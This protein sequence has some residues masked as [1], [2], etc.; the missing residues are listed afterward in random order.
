MNDTGKRPTPEPDVKRI[1]EETRAVK[2][3][4]KLSF[5][6]AMLLGL[7]ML[8]VW[9]AGLPVGRYLE[10]PPQTQRINPAPFSWIAFVGFA[11][12]VLAWLVPFIRQ[13]VRSLHLAK[14]LASSTDGARRRFPWWGW[15]GMGLGVVAWVMAWNRFSWF[16]R[17]QPHTFAPLWASYVIVMNALVYKR[18]GRC[19]ML[20]RTRFF[21]LLFPVS[22]AF[23]WFFEYLNRFVRNWHYVAADFGPWEYFWYAT[24]PFATVLPAV[25]GTCDL[26]R[27]FRVIDAGFARFSPIAFAK[28]KL[29]AGL[30]LLV[31][32]SGLTFIGVQPDYLFSLLWISPVVI[33]VSSQVIMGEWHI[34]SPLARGDWR[35]VVS[36]AAAAL[37]CGFFWEMWNYHSFAH[38]EYTVP[39]VQVVKIFEMP[40]IGYAGYLAFGL[41]CIVIGEML[42]KSKKGQL[43]V[44]APSLLE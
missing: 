35:L 23:W 7:P 1:L 25:L 32:A 29:V 31:T 9:L 17:L 5:L 2:T 11:L 38:W 43:K 10:F 30:A 21:L 18:T 3:V 14:E 39:F 27:S 8:G 40:I 33:I 44:E 26:I 12:F 34:F 19:M 36:G 4:A 28:P 22:A 41:E 37:I 24:L 15:S 16:A 20:D 13:A 6:S 42:A